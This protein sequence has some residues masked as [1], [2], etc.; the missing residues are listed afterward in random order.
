MT[1]KVIDSFMSMVDSVDGRIIGFE[2]LKKKRKALKKT[3]IIY[4]IEPSESSLK[5]L[6]NDF[7]EKI[8]E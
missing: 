8:K 3:H 2:N 5:Y 7:D 6:N 1:K 4:F